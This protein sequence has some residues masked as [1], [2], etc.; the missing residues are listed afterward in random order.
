M[1]ENH[2]CGYGP[3]HHPDYIIGS[4]RLG[5]DNLA[6]SGRVNIQGLPRCPV[7]GVVPDKRARQGH[8]QGHAISPC[9]QCYPEES[10]RRGSSICICLMPLAICSKVDKVHDGNSFTSIKCVCSWAINGMVRIW[11]CV[12]CQARTSS[13]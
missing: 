11:S 13:T 12:E 4:G 6:R 8:V 9:R 7:P 1:E 2:V 5:V 10:C 3:T